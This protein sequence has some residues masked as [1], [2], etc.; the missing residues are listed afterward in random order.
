MSF[1]ALSLPAPRRR[2]VT[3]RLIAT[4]ALFV[5]SATLFCAIVGYVLVRQADDRQALERRGA[6][7]AA[8]QDIRD[9]RRQ[10]HEARSGRD[11]WPRAH[12]RPEGSALRDRARRWRP[13]DAV[14][15]RR[16]RPHR[17][18]VQ[19]GAGTLH[20]GGA[21]AAPAAARA[22]RA[23]P[24]RFCRACALAGP[25]RDARPRPERKARVDA[26]AR[27]HADRPAQPPQDDRADRRRDGAN[28]PRSRPS[29]SPS[30]TSTA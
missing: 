21:E 13:R 29:R 4:L 25:P 24:D 30:S 5:I 12:R 20:G 8:I 14:G 28:A 3:P 9:V 18:L 11:P 19:L 2:V 23:L 7:L 10:L 27:G 15:A 1:A 17:R 22:D 26:G 6:L 16:A